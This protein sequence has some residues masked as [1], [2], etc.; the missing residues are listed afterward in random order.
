MSTDINIGNLDIANLAVCGTLNSGP[1]HRH[2][3]QLQG[4]DGEKHDFHCQFVQERGVLP[5]SCRPENAKGS[6]WFWVWRRWALVRVNPGWWARNRKEPSWPVRVGP[7]TAWIEG[8]D[9]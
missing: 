7:Y 9:L 3:L 6:S 1:Q 4:L 5:C 8:W 2:V